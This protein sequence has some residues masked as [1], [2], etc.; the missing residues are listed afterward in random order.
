MPQGLQVWNEN[1]VL[2]IDVT[3]RLGILLGNVDT[4]TSDGS[5]TVSNFSLGTPYFFATALSLI[6]PYGLIPAVWVSG[7]TLNW[8]FIGGTPTSPKVNVRIFYGVR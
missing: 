2:Q 6:P 3:S 4:G 8:Q 7:N 1:G 5:I